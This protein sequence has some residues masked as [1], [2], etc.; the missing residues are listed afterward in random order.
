VARSLV[1]ERRKASVLYIDYFTLR[2]RLRLSA[3]VGGLTILYVLASYFCII[4][5]VSSYFLLL[6][7][8]PSY[9]QLCDMVIRRSPDPK[10]VYKL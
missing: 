2:P 9:F 1:C 10:Y 3:G 8:C 7:P 5:I 4:I 6:G